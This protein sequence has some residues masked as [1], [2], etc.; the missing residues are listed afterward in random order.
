MGSDDPA[1]LW[2]LFSMLVMLLLSAY[3]SSTET[4]MMAVNRYRLRHLVKQQHKG[5]QRTDELLQRPDRLLGVILIGNNL[6]NFSAAT[7]ATVIGLE[8]FGDI[9]VAAAPV[10][11][12]VVFLILAEV[13]PKTIAAQ[14]PERIA[15]PSSLVLKPLLAL[16]SPVVWFVNTISNLIVSWVTGGTGDDAVEDLTS[17]EIRTLV[18]EN[19]ALPTR[20]QNMLL[21]VL[22]L[23]KV[24]VND[25]MVPRGEVI[26]IDLDDDM[27][28]IVALLANC[29]HTRLPV[30]QESINNIVGVLHLRRTAR[31]LKVDNPTLEDLRALVREAYFV[32]E[33]TPLNTQL[34]NFQKEKRRIALVVDEYGDIQG[35]VTLEDIL[36]EIVGE[37]TTDLAGLEEEITPLPDGRQ[38]IDGMALLRDINRSLQWQLPINGPRTLNGLV[39]EHLGVI[40]EANVCMLIGNYRLETQQISA[41]G[42]TSL[43]VEALPEDTPQLPLV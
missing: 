21:R 29:E 40:P 11:L 12:T 35:I 37:F 10:V 20:R 25:I 18:D 13:A 31:L 22:D 24:T 28:S 3:F 8:L 4:A 42:I 2:M 39:L 32:P 6:V 27:Q 7:L 5:A 30:Y 19:A 14:H 38:Q 36:E 17:E 33:A 23:E 16:L 1:L 41:K 26:G 15:F 34:V 43:I 9:G